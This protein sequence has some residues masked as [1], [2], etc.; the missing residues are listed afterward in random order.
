MQ[1]KLKEI[2]KKRSI[3][4]NHLAKLCGVK[5]Q[6]IQRIVNEQPP[7]ISLLTVG[8]LCAALACQPGDLLQYVEDEPDAQ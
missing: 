5:R 3:S 2:I 8:K 6:F 1:L 7:K 4:Q